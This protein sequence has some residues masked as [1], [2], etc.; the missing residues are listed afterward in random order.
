MLFEE[1]Q[2]IHTLMDINEDSR[3]MFLK[4]RIPLENI[5]EL[6]PDAIEFGKSRVRKMRGKIKGDFL[7]RFKSMVIGV[8]FDSF[9]STLPIHF[10]HEKEFDEILWDYMRD[11]FDVD[12]EIAFYDVM[13]EPES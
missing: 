1:L 2:R 8:L 7:P 5:E 13:N 10:E 12:M 9:F 11:R 3:T 6:L 4:R